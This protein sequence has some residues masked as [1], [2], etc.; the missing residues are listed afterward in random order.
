M[1]APSAHQFVLAPSERYPLLFSRLRIVT[2]DEF[3]QLRRPDAGAGQH[4]MHLSAMVSL[5]LEEMAQ[6]VVAAVLLDAAVTVNID[7]QPEVL[8]SQA[9]TEC[10]Q[11]AVDIGL[12]R[13]ERLWLG[14]GY[15]VLPCLR[16]ERSAFQRVDIEPVDDED[17]VERRTD[18][19]E[20]ARA[21]CLELS[22]LKTRYRVM[23]PEIG[24]GV[25]AGELSKYTAGVD[26]IRHG[27]MPLP[28][29][30]I[31]MPPAGRFRRVQR[32]RFP[33]ARPAGSES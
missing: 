24:Q 25:V 22:G 9:V 12:C 8:R 21:L 27:V 5:V 1:S 30:S 14:K 23:E 11:S 2:D 20:E 3:I 19:G 7:R 33:G 16:S 17:M 18:R 29:G 6:D 31:F 10:E 15:F 13:L 26:R 32:R 28:G 4:G